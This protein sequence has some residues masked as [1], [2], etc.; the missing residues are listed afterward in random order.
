RLNCLACGGVDNGVTAH[1]PSPFEPG[2]GARKC[3]C[4]YELIMSGCALASWNIRWCNRVIR[5]RLEG[6]H[7]RKLRQLGNSTARAS[8]HP[9]QGRMGMIGFDIACVIV[10]SGSRMQPYLVNDVCKL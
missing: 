1:W 2:D 4:W 9:S 5:R 7:G 10:R 3:T 6:F 8:D